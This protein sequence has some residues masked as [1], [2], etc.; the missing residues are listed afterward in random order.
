MCELNSA[1]FKR[2]TQKNFWA[3]KDIMGYN[4]DKPFCNNTLCKRL[5]AIA[6]IL[7]RDQLNHI[8]NND[9]SKIET[10]FPNYCVCPFNTILGTYYICPSDYHFNKI[11]KDTTDFCIRNLKI[12]RGKQ[13]KCSCKGAFSNYLCHP[14]Y[15]LY[16]SQEDNH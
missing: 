16:L 13:F 14:C 2:F 15:E 11:E 1:D 6:R 7:E 9:I 8:Y 4:C 12:R 5:R 10:G 3:K